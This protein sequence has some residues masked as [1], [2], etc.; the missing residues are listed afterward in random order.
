MK[1]KTSL[2]TKFLSAAVILAALL[3]AYH[4]MSAQDPSITGFE[5]FKKLPRKKRIIFTVRNNRPIESLNVYI[6]QGLRHVSVIADKNI[7]KEKTYDLILEPR[8]LAV[9]DGGATVV[10]AAR[11][12][13]FSK[14]EISVNSTVDTVPPAIKQVVSTPFVKQG[15]TGAVKARV[16][17]AENV[18]VRVGHDEF[19]M[20][21]S[22]NG[23]KDV[24]CTLFPVPLSVSPGTTLL[25]VAD[26]GNDNY[27]SERLDTTIVARKFRKSKLDVSDKFI[28]SRIMPLL[29]KDNERLSAAAAFKK[30]NETWRQEDNKA[31]E[32]A[33]RRSSEGSPL[34]KGRFLQLHG[35]RVFARFGDERDF[36]YRGEEISISRQLGYDLASARHTPVTAA[37]NGIVVYVGDRLVYG[38][39]VIVDHGLGLMSLYGHMSQ[40]SVRAGQH[41]AKGEIIGRTGNTGLAFGDYLHFG[42]Y[43]HGIAVNPLDWWDP[44]WIRNKIMSV[45]S[46]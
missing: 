10:I 32:G 35:S 25:V 24:Y 2:K 13:F 38:H 11:S 6:V 19:M 1:E 16:I 17:G 7:G 18:Y 30:I 23:K 12:S 5:T 40:T 39:T 37:N 43:V 27:R 3:F 45:L 44:N 4:C 41:L 21:K 34:W 36:Y 15:S 26:D 33:G 22:F 31:I 42:L 20:S 29:G 28:N 9:A 14:T 8:R 46:S